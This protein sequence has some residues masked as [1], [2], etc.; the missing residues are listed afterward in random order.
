[1]DA[2]FA[3]AMVLPDE[4]GPA[5]EVM[6]HVLSR[7]V[8]VPPHWPLEIA[9]GCLVASRRGRLS[10]PELARVLGDIVALSPE[11]EAAEVIGPSGSVMTLARQ[12]GLSA[13]DAAYLDLAVRRNTALASL[14]KALKRAATSLGVPLI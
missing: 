9:N 6:E 11:I 12:H 14:D 5:S 4:S 10:E 7:G 13:Y 1:M 2:S 3:L 8:C